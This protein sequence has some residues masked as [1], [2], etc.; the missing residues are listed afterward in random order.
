MPYPFEVPLADDAIDRL[1]D[2]V[3][4]SLPTELHSQVTRERL[5]A[6]RKRARL[7]IR[8]SVNHRYFH[9]VLRERA[10]WIDLHFQHRLEMTEIRLIEAQASNSSRLE[11]VICEQ[12][13]EVRE[14]IQG[15]SVPCRF[16]MEA[17]SGNNTHLVTA[18]PQSSPGPLKPD[19]RRFQKELKNVARTGSVLVLVDPYALA[20][21]DESGSPRSS[22]KEVH[23]LIDGLSLDKFVVYCRN[24]AIHK[25]CLDAL[26]SELKQKLEVRCGDFHDRYLLV[27]YEGQSKS[28][29]VELK[30]SWHGLTAW[31]GVV[32]GAS[33]NGISK[34]PTYVLKFEDNDIPV[35]SQYLKDA[36]PSRRML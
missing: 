3:V 23:E 34:R 14:T 17:D 9:E 4:D 28:P 19:P 12:L 27:G 1:V 22:A 30:D 10:N 24:D 5:T 33:L 26:A 20:E 21:T 29:F 35:I 2:I 6:M 16:Q 25:P 31:R 7:D 8:E 32:F 13:A 15:S 36:A 18:L 11:Q